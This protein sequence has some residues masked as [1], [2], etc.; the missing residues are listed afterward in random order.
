MIKT[1][2]MKLEKIVKRKKSTNTK[3]EG[4]SVFNL[5]QTHPVCFGSAK[6]IYQ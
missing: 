5:N 2:K 4:N 1:E 6:Q 3:H